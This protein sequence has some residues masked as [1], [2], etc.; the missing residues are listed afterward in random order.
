ML[1]KSSSQKIGSGKYFKG[2]W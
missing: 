1:Y 2:K